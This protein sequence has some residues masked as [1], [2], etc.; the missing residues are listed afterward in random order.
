MADHAP[1]GEVEWP[2]TVEHIRATLPDGAPLIL[3]RVASGKTLLD[4]IEERGRF[5]FP[6]PV[7]PAV[8]LDPPPLL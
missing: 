8:S 3:A 1:L 7:P 2:G 6:I 4:S 5:P